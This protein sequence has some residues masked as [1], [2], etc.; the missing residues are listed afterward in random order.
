[1][2]RVRFHLLLLTGITALVLFLNL[3]VA[4]L[5]DRDEPRNAGCALEMMQRGDLVVP[6][7]NDELRFQ[8]PALLYW[9]IISAYQMFGVS[10][11]AARFW[12]AVLALGS[13]LMTYCLGRHLLG[14]RAGFF[15]GLALGTSMMFVVAGR[16]ATPDSLLIFCSTGA[17]LV[18]VLGTFR[19]R[20]APDAPLETRQTDIWFPH[21]YRYVLGMYALMGLGVLAKGP[22]GFVLPCAII[23]MFLLI[24]RRQAARTHGQPTASILSFESM[25]VIWQTIH[26][27]HFLQTVWSMRPITLAVTVLTIAAPWYVAVGLATNGDWPRIF[28]L[29]ENL[30]RATTAFESHSGGLWYYP[31]TIVAGFFPA[32]IF[33]IPVA[34]DLVRRFR[35]DGVNATGHLFLVCWVGV[36]VGIFSVASTKL[37]SYITPCYPALA[38]LVGGWLS[39][40]GSLP[41]IRSTTESRRSQNW[42]A[43]NWPA[44]ALGLSGA[45]ISVAMFAI[46]RIYLNGTFALG[47]GGLIPIAGGVAMWLYRQQPQAFANAYLVAAVGFS[48]FVFGIG[49]VVVDSNRESLRL[50]EYV[51]QHDAPRMATFGCLESSWVFYGRRPVFELSPAG[52]G[53][54]RWSDDRDEF[55]ARKDW[56][57]PSE[58]AGAYEDGLILTTQDRVNELLSQLPEGYTTLD[59]APF[60]LKD[61]QLVLVGRAAPS[62]PTMGDPS[63]AGVTTATDS[64]NNVRTSQAAGQG[65]K[66]A[67]R[68]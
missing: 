6:M 34:I 57:S 14:A 23:G 18:Y 47:V 48:L 56:P 36:Q 9:L 37:P 13:V 16:A 61:E 55:W 26:P 44:L 39:G 3:G 45:G 28:F 43:T 10:E 65:D 63:S 46:G 15:G 41:T 7:F 62:M 2:A 17:L 68:R 66:S 19:A 53:R 30:G 27:W 12:S 42:I 5:W 58:F 59:T 54:P 24:V 20:E 29:S 51:A 67:E 11:F 22:V 52:T 49:T 35:E 40:L 60:F 31:M 21:Q 33:L 4:R 1:M 64:S 50:L 38:L 32:S 8:K 25:K